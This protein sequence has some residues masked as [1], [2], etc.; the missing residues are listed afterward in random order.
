MEGH[1]V[2]FLGVAMNVKF[3]DNVSNRGG[4]LDP[5]PIPANFHADMAEWGSVLRSIELARRSYNIVELG[6]G[7][8][9]WIN[10]T[11][12]VCRRKGLKFSLRLAW[13]E[14]PGIWNLPEPRFGQMAFERML[15]S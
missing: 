4:Q 9:S 6:C 14:M 13:K 3:M 11:G 2:N 1:I 7:W 15:A 8:G 5:L 10:N 12:V